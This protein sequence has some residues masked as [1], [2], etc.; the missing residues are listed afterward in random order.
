[1]ELKVERKFTASVVTDDAATAGMLRLC[2]DY[3]AWAPVDGEL[4]ATLLEKRG[5]VSTYAKLDSSA[6]AAMGFKDFAA[7]ADKMEKEHLRLSQIQGVRP[8]FRLAP[9]KGGFK[10]S[11]RRQFSEKGTLGRNPNLS[12]LVR[13]MI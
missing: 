8:F 2:K 4:L 11:L 1:M 12:E 10:L 3:I 7:L 5:R 13:R 6:L 9:P